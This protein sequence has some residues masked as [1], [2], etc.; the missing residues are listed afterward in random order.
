M[1][2]IKIISRNRN[3][4]KIISRNK[5][6][7]MKIKDLDFKSQMIIILIKPLRNIKKDLM[8]RNDQKKRNKIIFS[9]HYLTVMK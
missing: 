7:I 3:P 2:M 8:M 4:I 5:D 6:L 1:Q 9:N